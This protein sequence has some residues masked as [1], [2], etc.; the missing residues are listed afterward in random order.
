MSVFGVVALMLALIHDYW[1]PDSPNK[2]FLTPWGTI[3]LGFYFGLDVA[4]VG[5][6]EAFKRGKD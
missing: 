5:V 2:L 6:V 4:V 1:M 3:A